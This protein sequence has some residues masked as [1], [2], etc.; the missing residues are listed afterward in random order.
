MTLGK[1]RF[2]Q[3]ANKMN[4]LAGKTVCDKKNTKSC[5]FNEDC[6]SARKRFSDI[7]ITMDLKEGKRKFPLNFNVADLLQDGTI[8][9]KPK[10]TCIIPVVGREYDLKNVELGTLFLEKYYVSYD[11]APILEEGHKWAMLA[12]GNID[13][14]YPFKLDQEYKNQER[15]LKKKQEEEENRRKKIEADAKAREEAQRK[16]L[17]EKKRLEDQKRLEDEEKKRQAEKAA[18]EEIRAQ[19]EADMRKK[20]EEEAERKVLEYQQ[21]IEDIKKKYAQERQMRLDQQKIIDDLKS[22]L[23]ETQRQLA[24]ETEKLRVADLAI[25]N[26]Q[27]A[28]NE[29]KAKSAADKNAHDANLAQIA[30]D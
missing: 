29:L 6:T 7:T 28:I 26:L 4:K 8:A 19:K 1:K 22:L 13:D 12:V 18:E 2:D 15:D 3:F 23:A 17:E 14:S 24:L 10:N 20:I 16:A 9:A 30:K 25:L 27:K 21:Q 11:M 5:Y